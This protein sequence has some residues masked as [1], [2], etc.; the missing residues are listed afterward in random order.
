M[1]VKRKEEAV[2]EMR[3]RVQMGKEDMHSQQFNINEI[4]AEKEYY[5]E[6]LGSYQNQYESESEV[7]L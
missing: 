5:D 1:M 3:N 6:M 4:L 2:G 7:V